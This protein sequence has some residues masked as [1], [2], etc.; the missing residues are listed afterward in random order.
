MALSHKHHLYALVEREFRKSGEQVVKYGRTSVGLTERMAQYPKGSVMLCSCAI[1]P[2]LLEKA[3][4]AVLSSA[5]EKFRACPEIGREYFSGDIDAMI[6]HL[7]QA[8][9]KFRPDIA[10]KPE[11]AYLAPTESVCDGQAMTSDEESGDDAKTGRS[12]AEWLADVALDITRDDADRVVFDKGVISK[13]CDAFDT[14]EGKRTGVLDFKREMKAYLVEQGVWRSQDYVRVDGKL[15]TCDNVGVGVV[16]CLEDDVQEGGRPIAEWLAEEAGEIVLKKGAIASLCER[17][18]VDEDMGVGV[19]EF[20]EAV[21]VYL[22]DRRPVPVD[23]GKHMTEWLADVLEFTGVK[24]DRV[25]FDRVTMSALY[26]M[27]CSG[28]ADNVVSVVTFK[29]MFKAHMVRKAAWKDIADIKMP[30]GDFKS[31]RNVG[32]GVK[33]RIGLYG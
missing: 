30:G 1:E 3:E 8:A 12:V 32:M 19:V 33:L 14:D 5:R 13:L 6:C 20:R 16:V 2:A 9:V 28:L 21:K 22:E 26:N 11:P 7:V 23:V 18:N 4:A 25:V 24:T 17:Y 29:E 15:K 31:A 27:F 10:V